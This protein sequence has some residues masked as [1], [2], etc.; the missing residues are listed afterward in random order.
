METKLRGWTLAEIAELLGGELRGP[1]DVRVLRPVPSDSQDPNGITFAED[2]EH[3]ALAEK[4]AAAAVIV[5]KDCAECAKPTIVV[6]S[7]RQAFGL[8]LSMCQRPL[9]LNAGIHPTAVV[10]PGAMVSSSAQVGAFCVI[11]DGASIAEDACI[12]PFCYVGQ[13]CS[14]GR[15]TVLYPHV[16]LVQDVCIGA[17]CIIHSG[18]V[19]GADG[20]GFYQSEGRRVKVPQVGSVIVEDD[21]EI[22][23]NS[24]ID[25]AT[26]GD[27][28]IGRGT[29]IDN[30]VQIGHNTKVGEDG[31][32]AG[33]TGIS[34]SCRIGDRVTIGGQV[35]IADH[36]TLGDDVTLAGRSGVVK[37]LE[38]AGEYYGFPAAPI[39]EAM[40]SALLIAKLPALQA[41][42]R[43]LEKRLDDLE[44]GKQ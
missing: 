44:R 19:I 20:F 3:L 25:R 24:C 18:A 7:P 11:E 29:K 30:L 26:A 43:S 1:G 42:I 8:L 22:G 35:A 6:S 32:I 37:D 9:P 15:E 14:V 2:A 17:M 33:Q 39:K 12:H 21:V 41:K 36:T 4:S 38:R 40:R 5:A 27:T 10:H 23:A 34:G 16:V 28:I 31:V 13:G